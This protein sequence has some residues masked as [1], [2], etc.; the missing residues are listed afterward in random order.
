GFTAAEIAELVQEYHLQPYGQKGAWLAAQGLTYRRFRRWEKAIYDGDL[1]RALIPRNGGEVS[2]PPG[3][4]NA[5]A[6]ARAAETARH[7]AELARLRARVTELE[8]TNEALGKAIGLLHALNEHEPADT[9]TTSGPD[10]SSPPTT[11]SSP[12]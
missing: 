9:A 8:Q 4:R 12:S 7:E 3:K 6:N 10:S 11:P 2:T 5:M 1:D